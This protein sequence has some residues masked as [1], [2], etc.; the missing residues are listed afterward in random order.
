MKKRNMSQKALSCILAFSLLLTGSMIF[1]SPAKAARDSDTTEFKAHF[2]GTTASEYGFTYVNA[3]D[4][5]TVDIYRDNER[6][7]GGRHISSGDNTYYFDHFTNADLTPADKI[8]LVF[9]RSNGSE[10]LVIYSHGRDDFYDNLPNYLNVISPKKLVAGQRQTVKVALNRDYQQP[11][12]SD[13]IVFVPLD[14]NG[15]ELGRSYNESFFPDNLLI[16]GTDVTETFTFYVR[17]EAASYDVRFERYDTY[18]RNTGDNLKVENGGVYIAPDKYD[19][20]L[21]IDF[22]TNY[23]GLGEKIVPVASAEDSYGNRHDVTAA[24]TF[25][26]YGSAIERSRNDMF[27]VKSSHIHLNDRITIRAEYKGMVAERTLYVDHYTNSYTPTYSDA[28]NIDMAKKDFTIDSKLSTTFQLR[29][30]NG[31]ARALDFLPT[32]ATVSFENSS[33]NYARVQGYVY[34]LNSVYRDGSG[35]IE[36]SSDRPVSGNLVV[37]FSDDHGRYL[38]LRSDRINFVY[39]SRPVNKNV[40]MYINSRQITIGTQTKFIDSVPVIKNNRTYVPMRALA[41]AFG[42]QVDWNNNTRQVT[43]LSGSSVVVM[44]VGQRAYTVNGA[45]RTMDAEPY[46]DAA[47]G[48]TMV[49]VRFAAESLGYNV[50]AAYTNKGTTASILFSSK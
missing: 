20:N 49:P 18:A 46:I 7:V 38:T 37:T 12:P 31:T 6:L 4:N 29:N 43:V 2:I 17:P 9:K 44:T 1:V 47:T 11:F 13:K 28:I 30:T 34:N 5:A 15:N 39:T 10:L 24:T 36:V 45:V 26:F 23:V 33:N 32:K 21:R 42:A 22:P 35:I 40:I 16:D 8:K 19:R 48:R 50:A 41:E 27:I 25:S 14:K 3:P